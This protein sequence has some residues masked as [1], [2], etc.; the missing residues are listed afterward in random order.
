M[1]LLLPSGSMGLFRRHRDLDLKPL[2]ELHDEFLS[3][4]NTGELLAEAE[5]YLAGRED[6]QAARTER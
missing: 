5:D 1:A 3:R 2:A 4:P 6:G